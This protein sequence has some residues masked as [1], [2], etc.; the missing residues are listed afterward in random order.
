MTK[1]GAHHRGAGVEAFGPR[2]AHAVV[3]RAGVSVTCGCRT[4]GHRPVSASPGPRHPD[5]RRHAAL[6][7]RGLRPHRCVPPVIGMTW[8]WA[9]RYRP[10]AGCSAPTGDRHARSANDCT[11]PAGAEGLYPGTAVMCTVLSWSAVTTRR[12]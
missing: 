8:T 12:R 11:R 3:R 5:H 1:H 4:P 7:A 9:G 6:T 2:R 10:V